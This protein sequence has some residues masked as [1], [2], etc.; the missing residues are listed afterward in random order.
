L[1]AIINHFAF[2]DHCSRSA[3]GR[4]KLPLLQKYLCMVNFGSMLGAAFRDR[5]APR[6]ASFDNEG[7]SVSVLLMENGRAGIHRD[8]WRAVCMQGPVSIR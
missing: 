8:A 6:I 1:F 4:P 2:L 5:H 7:K 3:E